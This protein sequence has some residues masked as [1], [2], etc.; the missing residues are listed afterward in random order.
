MVNG[1]RTPCA[2][3]TQDQMTGPKQFALSM[4]RG[5]SVAHGRRFWPRAFAQCEKKRK[6]DGDSKSEGKKARPP[7]ARADEYWKLHTRTH[8]IKKT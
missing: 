3:T 4:E 1:G 7:P 2:H 6:K 5:A 8:L